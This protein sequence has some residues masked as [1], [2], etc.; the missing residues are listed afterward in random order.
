MRWDGIEHEEGGKAILHVRK[1]SDQA[2]LGA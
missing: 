2:E 1:Q